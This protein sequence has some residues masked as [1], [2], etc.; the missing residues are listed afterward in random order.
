MVTRRWDS[1]V[2]LRVDFAWSLCAIVIWAKT[3]AGCPCLDLDNFMP[4]PPSTQNPP[5]E[6]E[7]AD[8]G[9]E[10]ALLRWPRRRSVEPFP[11][12]RGHF[13]HAVGPTGGGP[14]SLRGSCFTL[15]SCQR[16]GAC[17]G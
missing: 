13:P 16:T 17:A 12:F 14:R 5:S 6:P 1:P 7:V 4:S 2:L 3:R 10:T 15:W 11:A 9:V 8:G